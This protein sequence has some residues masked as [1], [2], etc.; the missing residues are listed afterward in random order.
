MIQLKTGTP[1]ERKPG[2]EASRAITFREYAERYIGGKEA[3]WK[4]EKHRQQWRNSLRDYAMPHMGH[5]P[6]AD[7]DTEAVQGLRTGENPALWRGCVATDKLREIRP[8][9]YI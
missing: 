5:L 2:G 6:I 4:N 9:R 3:G 8:F 1:S 7:V